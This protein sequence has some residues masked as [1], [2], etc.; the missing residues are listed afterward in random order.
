[1]ILQ[2]I[3]KPILNFIYDKITYRIGDKTR[4][5]VLLLCF[6]AIFLVQFM[7]QYIFQYQGLNRGIR[8]YF[9][10]LVMG[11]M[12]LFSVDRRLELIKW[13]LWA[14]IPYTLA[15][16]LILIASFDHEMGPSYQAFP[17]TMLVAFMCLFYVWG[18]RKD[19]IVLFKYAA[20]AYVVYISCIFIMCVL[21][22]PYYDNSLTEYTYEYS[23][24]GINPNGVTKLF[25]P[26]VAC[27]VFL[28]IDSYNKKI[29]Y[30]Y[31]LVA[32]I[33]AAVILLTASRAGII[34]LIL[35]T[36]ILV[37]YIIS[38][39]VDNKGDKGM[40]TSRRLGK[41]LIFIIMICAAC[42]IGN[43]LIKTVSAEIN[44]MV[45]NDVD[46]VI[47]ENASEPEA[48]QSTDKEIDE[49]VDR[50]TMIQQ[51]LASVMPVIN[52]NETLQKLNVF[53]A[54]RIQIWTVYFQN[55]SWRGESELMFYD[56]EYAHNQ[57]IE[58]S[59]KAG[60]ATGIVYL[61]FVIICGIMFIRNMF[62]ARSRKNKYMWL[63]LLLFVVFFVISML[64]TGVMPF[65][66]GFIFLFY[67]SIS[68]LF[69]KKRD[70]NSNKNQEE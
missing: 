14:Y 22:Y 48:E 66:R 51:R 63:Q 25:A 35:M 4:N 8:D 68:E 37:C 1:M 2:H 3:Y 23:P 31:V 50:E 16:I 44:P 57:Y 41:H 7:A 61:I 56:T 13:N 39:I 32:G 53:M 62:D 55:I 34:V 65:E 30:M 45:G 6:L 42:C 12:I 60:I 5:I 27:A 9:I 28:A 54:G 46:I 67:I 26:G 19:Y 15:G 49:T 24:F 38:D 10:C 20:I 11:I 40:N 18:N 52:E 29:K 33:C 36:V 17:L 69:I 21:F 70:F 59:Y 43:V 47:S 64:D 58:L